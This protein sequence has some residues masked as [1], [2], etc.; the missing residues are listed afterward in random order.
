MHT[1]LPV[2]VPGSPFY[3]R[4]SPADGNSPLIIAPTK[5]LIQPEKRNYSAVE[6]VPT[7][8]KIPFINRCFSEI[9]VLTQK[10]AVSLAGRENAQ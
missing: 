7:P 6:V 9:P 10:K 3:K 8:G 5:D 2:S 4:V 1:A